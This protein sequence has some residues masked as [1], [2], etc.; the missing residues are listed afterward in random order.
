MLTR[1][2]EL[3][4]QYSINSYNGS[5][6]NE[7]FIIIKGRIPVIISS[8][9]TTNRYR[10]SQFK[11]ADKLTGGIALLLNEITGCHVI[12]SKSIA[13]Y[14][15]NFDDEQNSYQKELLTYINE[16]NIQ[17]L[18]DLHGSSDKRCYAIDIGTLNDD[19]KSLKN[20][21]YIIPLIREIFQNLSE[22]Y[23]LNDGEIT[24]NSTFSGGKQ[25]TVTNF[26]SEYSTCACAQLEINSLYRDFNNEEYL[27]CLIKTLITLIESLV[28]K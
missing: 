5:N 17:V 2:K 3:E 1:L 28:I 26:I 11:F 20:H 9:H 25:N 6:N 16:N 19:L 14:D 27:L 10:N 12:C 13:S 7:D 4:Y 8:P 15:P 23:R 24:V 21:K 18:L 22:K